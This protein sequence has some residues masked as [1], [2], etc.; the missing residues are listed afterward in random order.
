MVETTAVYPAGS[1][2]QERYS[3]EGDRREAEGQDER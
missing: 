1:G 2:G 3:R